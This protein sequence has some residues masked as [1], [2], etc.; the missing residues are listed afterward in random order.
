[1]AEITGRNKR[2]LTVRDGKGGYKVVEE[3]R[4][5]S[6]SKKEASEFQDGKRRVLI[7][8]GAGATGFSFH[9][10]NTA[11][12]KQQR[13]HYVLQPGWRADTAVQG[14]GRTHRTNQASAPE[15]VLVSTDV[16]AQKRFVSSI[17]RRLDQLGA[18]TKGQRETSGG[19]FNAS[20][21]LESKY[22]QA[23]LVALFTNMANGYTSMNLMK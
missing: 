6:A 19:L 15:Y 5:K 11:K 14:F 23:A 8:S 10:D 22:G 16:Q 20:D 2:Y 12:N 7:F 13:I 9:A 17:A 1:V 4:G 21:N 18:L 3:K